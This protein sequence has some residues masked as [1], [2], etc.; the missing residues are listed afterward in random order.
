MCPSHA[1]ADKPTSPEPPVV[2]QSRE[3]RRRLRE[4]LRRLAATLMSV[5]RGAGKPWAIYGEVVAVQEG[6]ERYRA[7]IGGYP[8][9]EELS[10]MLHLGPALE[11]QTPLSRRQIEWALSLRAAVSGGLRIAAARLLNLPKEEVAGETELYH[12]INGMEALRSARNTAQQPVQ[13]P[14]TDDRQSKTVE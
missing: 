5:S 13:A 11:S 4:E 3:A 8:S 12:G 2:Q 1:Q 10:A 6:F 14:D 7:V 9:P